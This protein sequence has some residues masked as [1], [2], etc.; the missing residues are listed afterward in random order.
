MHLHPLRNKRQLTCFLWFENSPRV[1]FFDG[2]FLSTKYGW[3]FAS[4]QT[5]TWL[6][7]SEA[8]LCLS[9][10]VRIERCE[11]EMV[12]SYFHY[13]AYY[14]HLLILACDHQPLT[15]KC[16]RVSYFLVIA[17]NHEKGNICIKAW[18]WCLL[19]QILYFDVGWLVLL[20][21]NYC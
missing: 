1:D 16:M 5:H 3:G 7:G 6:I 8:L 4:P 14:Y 19:Q 9:Q 20:H 2:L 15:A 21:L 10:P 11:G 18:S 17:V 13:S 12:S